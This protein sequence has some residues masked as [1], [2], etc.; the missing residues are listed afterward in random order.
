MFGTRIY[1]YPVVKLLASIK[2]QVPPKHAP[3]ICGSIGVI[4]GV[5]GNIA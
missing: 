4:L 2:S 1:P 5:V 3:K